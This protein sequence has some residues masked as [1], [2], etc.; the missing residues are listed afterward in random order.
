MQWCI[1]EVHAH[2]AKSQ[3]KI[4]TNILQG[5]SNI[6]IKKFIFNFS[7]FL[8]KRFQ[9]KGIQAFHVIVNQIQFEY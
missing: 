9:L 2:A 6:N 4:F 8:H 3:L 7:H 1:T 5:K